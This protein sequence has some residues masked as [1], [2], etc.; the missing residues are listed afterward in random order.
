[1]EKLKRIGKV[2]L[3]LLLAVCLVFAGAAIRL[4]VK[5]KK[6]ADP[7]GYLYHEPRFAQPVSVDNISVVQQDI[8]CGYAVLE[9]MGQWA[10]KD[11]TEESLFEEYGKVV[12]S[13]G[14]SFAKEMN[15]QFPEYQTTMLPYTNDSQMLEQIYGSL[16]KGIP[17]PFEWAAKKDDTWTLHYSLVVGLDFPADTVTVLNPYGYT[18]TVSVYEFLQ[19]TSFAAYRHMPLG[20]RLGFLFGVFEKNTIFLLEPVIPAGS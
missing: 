14:K 16:E 19:R 10:Q 5:S 12:T 8:S 1:M 6:L 20:L 17:V 11:V 18:E 7:Y 15:R 9:M 2:L 13:T 4:H 3:I